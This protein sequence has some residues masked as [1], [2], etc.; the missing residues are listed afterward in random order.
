M[1][2]EPIKSIK[3]LN[4]V[5]MCVVTANPPSLASKPTFTMKLLTASLATLFA[6]LSVVQATPTHQFDQFFPGWNNDVQLIL[7]ENCSDVYAEYLTGKVNY[8]LGRQSLV[9]PVTDCILNV[10]SET[11]KAERKQ[12]ANKC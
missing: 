2:R 6:L 11:K 4:S 5:R 1:K 10:F 12:N 8:T 9:S 3:P 7:R